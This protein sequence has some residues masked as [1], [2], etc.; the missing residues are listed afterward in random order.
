MHNKNPHLAHPKYRPDIDGLRA[1]AVL[2]VV[3]F[4]AFPKQF[5][6]GF[7]GVDIF[8]VI[9]GFLISSIIFSSLERDRF[10]FLEFYSRRIKRIFP[11]LLLVL[12]ASILFGGMALYSDEYK[13]LGQ[14]IAG[15][16]GFV[17]NFVLWRDSGYFDSTAQTKPLLHLW[18]LAIEDQFY[19]FWPLLLAWAWRRKW[20]FL[21]ITALIG[22]A[23]FAVNVYLTNNNLTAAFY[24]PV[25]RFWELMVGGVLAF[26]VLHRPTLNSQLKNLQSV[27]GTALLILGFILINKS[28]SFPGWWALL[29]TIGT[30]L[31]I[32]AGSGA[33][34]NEHVFSNKVLVWFGLISYPLYL[35]H[36]PLLSFGMIIEATDGPLPGVRNTVIVLSVVLAWL[37]YRFVEQPVRT[38]RR[39][40]AM[41]ISSLILMTVIGF[42]GYIIYALDGL[43][44][45]SASTIAG[46]YSYDFSFPPAFRH[47]CTYPK[48]IDDGSWD[49]CN[50]G[51]VE[52]SPSVVLLGDSFA[53]SF[54]QTLKRA[55]QYFPFTFKQLGR[56]QCPPLLNYGPPICVEAYK[57]YFDWIKN[58]PSIKVV[59]LTAQWPSYVNGKRYD[60]ALPPKNVAS[61]EF[62]ESFIQSL[63]FLVASN[64]RVVI[65]L[66]PPGGVN[67]RACLPRPFKIFSTCQIPLKTA[68][69]NDQESRL[70]INKLL[71]RYPQVKIYDPYDYLCSENEICKVAENRKIFYIDAGHMSEQ[72][73]E[74]LAEKSHSNLQE[75]FFR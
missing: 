44:Y 10:S 24:S 73:G 47:D 36:W 40:G 18:S 12:L 60:F 57:Y 5:I 30:A 70:I 43:N 28:S 46:S 7:V 41:A 27:I 50:D 56:G 22:I 15:G 69:K 66:A 34:L 68:L 16:A 2:S 25:S 23:S 59:V 4:H 37:T 14:H 45:R 3:G 31:V 32:S 42:S 62:Q 6:G 19:I 58:T 75:L 20:D 17:S 29:P 39:G 48:K 8:F 1:I 61:H 33:W 65:S 74:F 21:K 71:L 35:W 52:T 63:D 53:G 64:K 55:S 67:P 51:N 26:V 72:G 49:W 38:G 11:S 13:Q 9:S 54:S